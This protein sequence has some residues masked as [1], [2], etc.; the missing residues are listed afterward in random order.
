MRSIC[1]VQCPFLFIA[2][3]PASK[4]VPFA[5]WFLSERMNAKQAKIFG[6]KNAFLNLRFISESFFSIC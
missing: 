2:Q 6:G 5:A 1:R 3:A 4:S